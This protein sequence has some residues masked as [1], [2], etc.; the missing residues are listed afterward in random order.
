[1][2]RAPLAILALALAL[3][4][5]ACGSDEPEAP[6]SVPRATETVDD[7]PKLPRGFEEEISRVNGLTFGRPP[8]WKVTEKGIATLLRAPDELV[9]VSLAAD[10]TDEA[11]GADPRELAVRTFQVL[12]GY[13][14]ELDPS[15]PRAFKHPYDAYEVRGE[16]VAASTGVRQRLRV[17]VLR[18]EGMAVV[19]AVIAEN[20]DEKAPYE[21]DQALETVRTL[22]TRPV[23]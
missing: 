19:T 23:G 21:V 5:A 6:P 1:M 8:G 20:L 2:P 7:L 11:V 9:V 14:G 18:R 17:I 13:K 10:R 15:E 4:V 3:S 12:E 16:G 22:R